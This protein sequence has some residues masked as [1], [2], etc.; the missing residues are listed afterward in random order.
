MV[1]DG[2]PRTRAI[3]EMRQWCATASKYEGLYSTVASADLPTPAETAAFEFDFSPA[4][5]F[6]GMRGAMV[7]MARK[8]DLIKAA[9]KRSWQ[10]DPEHPDVVPLQ[11]ATQLQQLIEQCAELDEMRAWPDDFRSWMA[12]SR[13]QSELL[14]QALTR[15]DSGAGSA[16]SPDSA[17]SALRAGWVREADEAQRALAESCLDCHSSYR[18]R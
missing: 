13:S 14:V 17:G 6:D 10:A 12:E 16:G 18:N 15:L 7:Q 5:R 4:H 11:E 9:R 8:W 2:I 3:A 1:L